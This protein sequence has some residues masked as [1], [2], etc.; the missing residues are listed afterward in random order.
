M[1]K[2]TV[3]FLIWYMHFPTK[4]VGLQSE[5]ITFLPVKGGAGP[6][7]VA[8][9][10]LWATIKAVMLLLS[11]SGLSPYHCMPWCRNFKF[12]ESLLY[13]K[14]YKFLC[15]VDL[16]RT[17]W[18][19]CSDVC[20][21]YAQGSTTPVKDMSN[22]NLVVPWHMLQALHIL[23]FGCLYQHRD[24]ISIPSYYNTMAT[25]RYCEGFT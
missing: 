16:L 13:F 2:I 21:L 23:K 1:L 15:L 17:D 22:S 11:F 9:H 20:V 19:G 6:G 5:M 8:H 10:V 3:I 14:N 12:D 4:M 25:R 24:P 18:R 7:G